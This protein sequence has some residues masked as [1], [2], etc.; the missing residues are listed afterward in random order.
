MSGSNSI[1]DRRTLL[2]AARPGTVVPVR[3]EFTFDIDTAV[4]AYAKLRSGP[5][6]FLLE[7]VEGG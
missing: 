2:E 5:F 1:P 6:G 7:S 4:T 3:I